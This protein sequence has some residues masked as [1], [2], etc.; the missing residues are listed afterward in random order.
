MTAP[1]ARRIDVKAKDKNGD[2]IPGVAFEWRAGDVGAGEAPSTDGH[3][4]FELTDPN[5]VVSVKATFEGE[6]QAKKLVVG[7]TSYEF[8]F[9]EVE[10]NPQWRSFVMKHF[11]ALIGI[12]FIL[13]TVVLAVEMRDPTAFQQHV[14]LATL[15]LGA[16]GFGGE[17]AGFINLDLTLGKK[18]ALSAGGA[19]AI[20]VLLYFFVPAGVPT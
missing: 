3:V 7:Q 19:V 15:S 6:S 4:S 13:L 9:A 5:A 12:A 2:L 20:F 8:R 17:I 14:I 18:L 11:P 16:G 1:F 10:V